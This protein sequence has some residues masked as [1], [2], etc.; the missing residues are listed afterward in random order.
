MIYKGNK[1]ERLGTVDAYIRTNRPFTYQSGGD[2]VIW[3]NGD[4]P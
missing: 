4:S 1:I 3:P 2:G